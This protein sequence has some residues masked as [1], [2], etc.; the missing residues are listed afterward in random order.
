MNLDAVYEAILTGNAEAA[1]SATN[2]SLEKG[3]SAEKILYEGCIPAMTEVGRQFEIGEKFVPEMLISARAM[4]AATDILRPL[5]IEEG[6]QQIGTIILGTVAG[7]LHDIG[8]NLVGMMMEGAGFKIIN[9]GADISPE[10]FVDAVNEYHPE[11]LAMSALLTTTTRSI[12]NTIAALE[13]AGIR[14]QVIVMIG[15][16]PITQDFADKVGADGFAPD[17]ASAARKAKE[18]IGVA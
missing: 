13:E 12:I 6:V 4:T 10:A 3:L 17:A 5:L 16:A 18:L 8:K 11:I 7:D 14:D 1:A 2:A 15:G 9:L